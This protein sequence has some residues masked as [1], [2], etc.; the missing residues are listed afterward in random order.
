MS[1]KFLGKVLAG[2]A[3]GG[4]MLLIA[5]GV[6]LADDGPGGDWSHAQEDKGATQCAPS[7]GEDAKKDGAGWGEDAKKDEKGA[8]PEVAKPE[9]AKKDGAGWGEDA[10]KDEKGAKP[11]VAKPEAAKE[12]GD[13]KECEA[14]KGWVDGGDAGS[15]VDGTLATAGGTLLGAAALG[16]IVLMRRRRT[17]G[18][19]A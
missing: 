6:A 4:A 9:D 14:P 7:W 8:K 17:D 18:S 5:P 16:G 11:E 13:K 15:S 12:D 10:K 2:A 3:L 19:L 1:K